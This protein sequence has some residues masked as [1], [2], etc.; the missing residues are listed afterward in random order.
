MKRY[1][2]LV[3]L[4][5]AW[6]IIFAFFSIKAPAT[7]P[8]LANFETLTRQVVIVG[9]GA[10]GMTFIIITGG[11]DLSAGSLVALVTVV[12]ATALQKGL[13]PLL[14]ASI[15]IGAGVLFGY[16]NGLLISRLNVGAFIVTLAGLTAYRGAAKGIANGQKVNAPLTWLSDLTA[17]L[18]PTEKWKLFSNGA[19]LML[20]CAAIASWAIS[21]TVFGRHVVAV[22]SNEQ[23]A[24]L[25]G[26]RVKRVKTFV[27]MLAGLCF[28][29]SG[30]MQFSRLTVG[31]PTVAVGLELDIIAA[32][33]IGGASLSGGEGSI[34]GSLIG[35]MIMTTIKAGGSQ[36]GWENWIQEIATGAIILI[37]VTFDRWRA[38]R[39]ATKAS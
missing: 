31:D 14:A 19:W 11:I 39:A 26:I 37:A 16:L 17:S 30:L 24:M 36:L 7:F 4:L 34:F 32:V 5:G 9:F 28:G 1:L 6:A 21:F 8:T 12:I 15:G 10:I 33:V 22:G 18:A 2:N 27:Y 25:S 29:L 20:I 13:N 23:A 38:T 35:A 3:G